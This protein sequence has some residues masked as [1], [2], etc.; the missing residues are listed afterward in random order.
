MNQQPTT[1]NQHPTS[2]IQHPTA[3][4]Q[5]DIAFGGLNAGKENAD[6]LVGFTEHEPESGILFA[7]W[8]L[9]VLPFPFSY[10]RSFAIQGSTPL[11]RKTSS[12]AF[13]IN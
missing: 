4:F 12:M 6:Q 11:W 1:N 9:D 3:P 8:M 7:L 5:G 13:S 2:N 10:L